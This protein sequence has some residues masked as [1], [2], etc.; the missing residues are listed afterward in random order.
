EDDFSYNFKLLLP[1]G[2]IQIS[3]PAQKF[4]SAEGYGYM[5]GKGAVIHDK[6]LFRKYV[7]A[8]V[9]Q[10]HNDQ[11]PVVRYE[12]FGWKDEGKAFLWGRSLFTASNIL[13]AN[14]VDEVAIRGRLLAPARSGSFNKWK[15]AADRL[16]ARD[17]EPHAFALLC[18][19]A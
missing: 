15:A 16:F 19:F 14:A 5:S 9:D 18:A 3:L 4:H 1:L 2:D 6:D 7:M 17:C 11:R 8:A 12:Q 13:P 10:F